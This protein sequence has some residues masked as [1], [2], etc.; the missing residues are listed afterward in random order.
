ML[1]V[2]RELKIARKRVVCRTCSWEGFG[3]E[4]STGLIRIIPEPIYF[5][6]YRCPGCGGF[7]LTRKGKLLLFRLRAIDPQEPEQAIPLKPERA[8]P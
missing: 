1:S 2:G 6:A 8:M 5:Y 4:L 3:A 7:D